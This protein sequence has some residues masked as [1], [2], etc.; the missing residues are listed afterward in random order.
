MCDDNGVLKNQS[1]RFEVL[2]CSS[3]KDL[4]SSPWN[5][6]RSLLKTNKGVGRCDCVK[7]FEEITQME[8]GREEGEESGST[9]M[10][11]FNSVGVVQP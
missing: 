1:I 10:N 7:G 9:Y 6:Q 3:C 11:G 8:G 2:E 4:L 5:P